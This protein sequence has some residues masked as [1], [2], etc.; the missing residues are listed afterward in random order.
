MLTLQESSSSDTDEHKRHGENSGTHSL[1]LW[2]TWLSAHKYISWYLPKKGP[3][4]LRVL[5]VEI[6]TQSGGSHL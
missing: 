6:S 4:E 1:S 3:F 5:K 2:P